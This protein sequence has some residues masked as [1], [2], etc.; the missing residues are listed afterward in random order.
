MTLP[1]LTRPGVDDRVGDDAAESPPKKRRKRDASEVRD[2]AAARAETA[3]V[4]KERVDAKAK[5]KDAAKRETRE[6]NERLVAACEAAADGVVVKSLA[7][8]AS[9]ALSAMDLVE[10][11][12]TLEGD[13]VFPSFWLFHAPGAWDDYRYGDW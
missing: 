8:H 4:K 3:R 13:R 2:A 11:L 5:K 12:E 7:D 9:G 10:K 1:R 6:K